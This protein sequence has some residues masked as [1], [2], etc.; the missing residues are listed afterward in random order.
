MFC[1]LAVSFPGTT[2]SPC[3]AAIS[4]SCAG[5][6]PC[7]PALVP[8]VPAIMNG[9]MLGPG[10]GASSGTAPPALVMPAIRRVAWIAVVIFVDKV[11][12]SSFFFLSSSIGCT[13]P[14]ADSVLSFSL[15]YAAQLGPELG[16]EFALALYFE[17]LSSLLLCRDLLRGM[18]RGV[19]V[20]LGRVFLAPLGA[21]GI[22]QGFGRKWLRHDVAVEPAHATPLAHARSR[23]AV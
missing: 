21:V 14:S 9:G 22:E 2:C 12:S 17:S 10:L 13:L 18:A 16:P 23:V 8:T 15:L 7:A 6:I 4:C 11:W 19:L 5:V 3:C 1:V 20:L